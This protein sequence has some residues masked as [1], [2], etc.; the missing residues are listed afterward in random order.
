MNCSVKAMHGVSGYRSDLNSS[1]VLDL[2]GAAPSFNDEMVR[3]K[4]LGG[5]FA[6]KK[7]AFIRFF[8]S[9]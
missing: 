3:K 9:F 1:V 6:R 7:R 2:I 5:V 8:H 4:H